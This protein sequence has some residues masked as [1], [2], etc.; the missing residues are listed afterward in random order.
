M[1]TKFSKDLCGNNVDIT[2]EDFTPGGKSVD[3][4]QEGFTRK[5]CRPNSLRIYVEK[6]STKF[7][8]DL[9]EKMSTKF[10]KDLC[11]K[12]VDKNPSGFI[13]KS[14]KV[15]ITQSVEKSITSQVMAFVALL[16]HF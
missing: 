16:A 1:W 6:L 7:L 11:G 10:L 3:K 14:F 5:N 2:Q 9:C 13:R 8:E 12:N 15:M 4:I